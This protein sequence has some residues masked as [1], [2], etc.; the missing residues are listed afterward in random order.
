MR[1]RYAAALIAVLALGACSSTPADTAAAPAAAPSLDPAFDA[2]VMTEAPPPA[3]LTPTPTRSTRAMTRK[4]ACQ[5]VAESA[6]DWTYLMSRFADDPG[7]EEIS[8]MELQTLSDRINETLRY[9][10]KK[11]A[12]QARQLVIPV[13]AMYA[14]MVS[15]TNMRIQLE[16]GRDAV[17]AIFKGCR[18]QADLS[19][20]ESPYKR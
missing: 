17:P 11:T 19:G 2:K 12:D 14:V 7:M 1:T 6:T 3:T 10:D 15:Q 8:S 9:L 5:Q 20:Y 13:D 18:G 4:Q 16:Q